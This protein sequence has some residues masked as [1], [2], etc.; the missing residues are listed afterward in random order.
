MA[1]GGESQ[2]DKFQ[3][4]LCW[5][6]EQLDISLQSGKLSEKQS[7]DVART[8]K[9][10]NNPKA[11]L[12]KKRQLMRTS[13]GDYRSKMQ[14]EEKSYKYETSLKSC[15]HQ[16]PKKTIFLKRK[17]QEA[18]KQEQEKQ[19][20]Q[21]GT[22]FRFNFELQDVPEQVQHLEDKSSFKYKKSDNS[23]RFNFDVKQT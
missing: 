19:P 13:L 15:A 16:L 22:P 1:E 9:S 11:P 4:E 6:L 5:C 7:K 14:Q 18:E 21:G 8:I 2:E 23:F 10:L 3:A 20:Q 17:L 12:V